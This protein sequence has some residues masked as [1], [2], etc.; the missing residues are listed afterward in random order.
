MQTLMQSGLLEPSR[1][2]TARGGVQ[3]ERRSGGIDQEIE[4]DLLNG[5]HVLWEDAAGDG[6]R[7]VSE[8]INGASGTSPGSLQGFGS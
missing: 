7:N 8:R 5:I 6:N 2:S 3:L 1:V 4:F